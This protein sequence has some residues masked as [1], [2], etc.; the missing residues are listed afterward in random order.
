MVHSVRVEGVKR[1][2]VYSIWVE[3]GY[4]ILYHERNEIYD[5]ECSIYM[6]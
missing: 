5:I 6:E 3:G 2:N 1:R 4:E